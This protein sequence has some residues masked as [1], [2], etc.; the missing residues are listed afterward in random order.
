MSWDQDI[1]GE[2]RAILLRVPGL[3][4]VAWQ[5]RD[6]VPPARTP[7]VRERLAWLPNDLISVGGEYGT[8]RERGL[9]LL[10][11]FYPRDATAT[12]MGAMVQTILSLYRPGTA[13]GCLLGGYVQRAGRAQ[14]LDEPDLIQAPLTIRWFCDRPNT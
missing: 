4:A 8:V 7:W 3:P 5:H 13:L 12:T 9:Y 14:D 6:F 2:L 11:V 10:D 1:R